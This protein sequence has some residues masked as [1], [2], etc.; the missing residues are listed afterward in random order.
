MIKLHKLK[1][2]EIGE[3]GNIRFDERLLAKRFGKKSWHLMDQI[4]FS[5]IVGH[6]QKH[7]RIF[8]VQEMERR[9]YVR[10]VKQLDPKSRVK[11]T[12]STDKIWCLKK[13]KLDHF[14][15]IEVLPEWIIN[16]KEFKLVDDL[17]K[18]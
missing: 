15:D 13:F 12:Q 18:T 3:K 6:V 5:S 7:Q 1:I 2:E 16:L 14:A 17:I 10:E 4:Q 9:Q 11:E 8:V